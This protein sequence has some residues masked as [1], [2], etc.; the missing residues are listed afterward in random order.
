MK[1]EFTKVILLSLKSKAGS[2]TDALIVFC[3]LFKPSSFIEILPIIS[4]SV[5]YRIF[6]STSSFESSKFASASGPSAALP[7]PTFIL[8]FPFE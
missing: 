6:T 2:L 5:I 7:A 3:A 4:S 1:S 8:N